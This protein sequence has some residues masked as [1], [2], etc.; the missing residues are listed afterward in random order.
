M[1]DKG[2]RLLA[3]GV[4]PPSSGQET[5]TSACFIAY[6]ASAPAAL[7]PSSWPTSSWPARDRRGAWHVIGGASAGDALH[8][9]TAT[10]V[11]RKKLRPSPPHTGFVFAFFCRRQQIGLH[12]LPRCLFLLCHRANCIRAP[13]TSIQ[14]RPTPA[15]L[16]R[17]PRYSTL[18]PLVIP[19]CTR[20]RSSSCVWPLV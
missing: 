1:R 10:L 18:C 14:G 12:C 13:P 8:V 11:L 20:C 17:F 3:V 19:I 7:H 5:Q 2:R 9:S 4:T 15:M 6:R 16:L